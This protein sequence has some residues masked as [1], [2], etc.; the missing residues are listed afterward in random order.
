MVELGPSSRG[1]APGGN[2]RT[3]SGTTDGVAESEGDT[4]G[5]IATSTLSSSG[6]VDTEGSSSVA[7]AAPVS[8]VNVTAGTDTAG[9]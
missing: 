6:S 4:T 3:R 9:I 2:G 7:V 1:A 8:T 5:G